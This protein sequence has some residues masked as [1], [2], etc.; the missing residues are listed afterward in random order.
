MANSRK[1]FVLIYNDQWGRVRSHS[2]NRSTGVR[3]QKFTSLRE[4][5]GLDEEEFSS[6]RYEISKHPI[7]SSRPIFANAT[8]LT[9]AAVMTILDRHRIPTRTYGERALV[10][11]RGST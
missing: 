2:S 6:L 7:W 1:T 4:F 9:T 11:A 10:D 8:F 3:L 5:L